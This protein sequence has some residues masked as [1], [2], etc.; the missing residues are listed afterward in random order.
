MTDL[1]REWKKQKILAAMD[2]VRGRPS[3]IVG[4]AYQIQRGIY[5][6]V[7]ELTGIEKHN[8]QDYV[9]VCKAI[10]GTRV[11]ELTYTH[12]RCDESGEFLVSGLDGKGG[13]ISSDEYEKL[14][15]EGRIIFGH[16]IVSG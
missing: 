2:A 7:A 15:A 5:D 6:R 14:H 10:S 4:V 16:R 8:L 12:H 1:I 9:Q 13:T 3:R 11:P